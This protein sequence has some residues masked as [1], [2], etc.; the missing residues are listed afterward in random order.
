MTDCQARVFYVQGERIGSGPASSW[1]DWEFQ[2][3]L[4]LWN[5][6]MR[7]EI[8]LEQINSAASLL[9]W[10][11]HLRGRVGREGIWDLTQAFE[12]IF[13]PRANCCSFGRSKAFSGSDLAKAYA[14]KLK[15][16]RIPIPTALRF[17]VLT[18]AAYRCQ[19]CGAKAA[20]GAELH[21][22][23]IHPV[24]KGGTNDPTNLQALCRDCN[25]GKG[26]RVL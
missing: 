9:D 4:T 3:N 11:F 10:I 26:A 15:P 24:S 7:Y 17:D 16:K 18:K 6:R 8:D 1:G 21:I 25:L 19:A 23:H 12:D 13:C 5:V 20:D 14:L 2:E 22:D